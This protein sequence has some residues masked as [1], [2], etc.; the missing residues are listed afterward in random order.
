MVVVVMV[1]VMMVMVVPM[2]APVERHGI[3]V[4]RSRGRGGSCALRQRPARNGQRQNCRCQ[5]DVF[6]HGCVGW[7]GL[8]GDYL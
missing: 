2:M 5:C 4:C 7:L 8:L 1:V 3:G 6:V